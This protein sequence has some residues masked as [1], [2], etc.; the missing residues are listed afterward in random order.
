MRHD[1]SGGIDIGRPV[2]VSLTS[3][4][5]QRDDHHV[6]VVGKLLALG[7]VVHVE[8]QHRD[9]GH[10][11][12]DGPAYARD[13]S[14]G[15]GEQSR[16]NLAHV[17]APHDKDMLV[18]PDGCSH[19]TLQHSGSGAALYGPGMDPSLRARVE[20]WI[21]AD[22]DPRAREE[23]QQL[24]ARQDERELADRFSGRLTFGTAGIRGEVAAGPNRINLAVAMQTAWG[25]ARVVRAQAPGAVPAIVVGNDARP[26]SPRFAASIASVLAA[27]DID[28]TCFDDPVPT[29]LV[30]WKALAAGADAAIVVTASHNPRPDNGIK[31]YDRRAV[32]ITPPMDQAI[33]DAIAC[34][35]RACDIPV[36]PAAVR[37]LGP[38][39]ETAYRERIV[40]RLSVGA[41]RSDLVVV[42]TAL[43]GVG[44]GP[45]E[46]LL[47]DAGHAVH[48][49]PE[50][51]EPDG[52]FPTTP[53]PNPEEPGVL[54]LA[55]ALGAELGADV[56]LANDPDADRL[57]VAIPSG[58]GGHAPLTGNEVG[59]LLADALLEDLELR[60]AAAVGRGGERGHVVASS[61]VSS[62]QLAAVA[63][64]HHAEHRW[65]LTGFKWI[66]SALLD[67]ESAGDVPVFGYEEALGYSVDP[68][69]R[70]KDGL[71]AA[72]A[73]VDLAAREAARGRTLADRLDDLARA[74]GVWASTQR[75]LRFSGDDPAGVMALQMQRLRDHPPTTSAALTVHSSADWLEG[76]SERPAWLGAQDLLEHGVDG[77]VDGIGPIDGRVLVRPSG[78]E[79][80]LKVYVDLRCAAEAGEHPRSSQPALT[81]LAVQVAEAVVD[82]LGLA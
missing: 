42:A 60:E 10:G 66:W 47:A 49:V 32:Q 36:R 1:R 45:L 52:T 58:T 4:G 74:T 80:K 71:S 15:G 18:V 54:D 48:H 20:A 26:D 17:A 57:A 73:V 2:A 13:T 23:L 82:R 72:L 63:A 67:A 28:V 64:R 46:R 77:H 35:P 55:L 19:G 5:R 37:W 29:P 7:R 50:Q 68:C 51:R 81:R 41:P 65:T 53:F 34:A 14:S 75:S 40:A 27:A 70:D 30:A 44:A 59:V 9:A 3:S 8:R 69:V 62:P 25:I 6:G 78:T 43:H 12:D 16:R 61:I 79:P 11:R 76:A 31:V 39:Q 56:I 22:P 21:D 24:L 33:A 38:E